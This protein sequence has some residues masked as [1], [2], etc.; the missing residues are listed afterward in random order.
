MVHY[1][2]K[3]FVAYLITC[4]LAGVNLPIH[5]Q[6]SA[7]C[8]PPDYWDNAQHQFCY[9]L[10]WQGCNYGCQLEVCVNCVSQQLTSEYCYHAFYFCHPQWW[11]CGSIN[12]C[13]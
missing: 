2:R 12:P 4:I 1:R 13:A 7:D 10:G 6:L 8:G 11:I 5:S 9:D 3:I